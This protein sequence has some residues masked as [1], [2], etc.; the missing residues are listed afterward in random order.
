M[1]YSHDHINATHHIRPGV[2]RVPSA[3]PDGGAT[4]TTS[5][6]VMALTF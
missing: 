3:G 5:L 1:T 4:A 2:I 6:G